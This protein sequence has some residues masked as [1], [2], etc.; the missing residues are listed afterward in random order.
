MSA[1]AP[2]LAIL[3]ELTHRCP[4]QCPYCSN[5]R[6]LERASAELRTEEWLRVLAEAAALG[7]LQVHLSG[8]EPTARRDLEEIVR[9]ATD[10][11]LY[12][13]LITSGVL[14]DARRVAQLAGAGLEHVQLSFQ[15]SQAEGANRIAGF[16]GHAKKLEVAAQ[17]RDAGLPLTANFV[18][19]RQN[20]AHLEAMI[21]L[22]VALGA[23]RA[24]IAHVQYYG[25]ALENRGAFFPTREQLDM[26][27]ATVEHA[28]ETLAGVLAIDYVVPDY[29][30]RRPKACMGGWGR[31]FL[32]VTPSGKV[33]PC[34]AAES[35]AE[36][37]F[38]NV[39]DRPLA[40]IWRD[41]ESFNRFRGTG[42]MP[43]PCRSC[44][45]AQIDWG[46]CRCQAFA[47][48][49]DA[50]R[51]DPVC[52]LAPDH[53]RVAEIAEKES[54]GAPKSFVYRNFATAP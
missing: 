34:H 10:C 26:A 16:A 47:L 54:A 12:T 31:R 14:L 45:R 21:D 11:G 27:T 51:T 50:A 7:C 46:G 18:V 39:R 33:L 15:D 8:G 28:R 24:E 32:N 17:V 52:A 37:S 2:P 36:L 53:A 29:Y 13:N 9:G 30:A 44:E 3:A 5:P 23:Q 6:A 41:S 49:G 19:H 25:W 40:E 4:L 38:E 22:A 48:T 42:W 1:P 35:I 43:E 20:L